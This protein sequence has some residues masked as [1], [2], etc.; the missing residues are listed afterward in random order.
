MFFCTVL[1]VFSGWFFWA[2]AANVGLLSQTTISFL[3]VDVFMLFPGCSTTNLTQHT[4]YILNIT[5]LKY[6]LTVASKNTPWFQFEV[7]QC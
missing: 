5:G 1:S 2:W 6:E 4:A 7:F 3:C